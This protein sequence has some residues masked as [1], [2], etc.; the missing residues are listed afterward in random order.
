MGQNFV[1]IAP[2][3][4]KRQYQISNGDWSTHFYCFFKDK[5]KGK[6]RAFPLG[7]DLKT[8]KD[9]LK[10]LEARNIRK[11]DFD[12]DKEPQEPKEQGMTFS[13]WTKKYLEL[14]KR[15]KSLNRDEQ[16]CV[17]LNRFFGP[18]LLAQIKRTKIMEYKNL[19]LEDPIIRYGKPVEGSKVKI[20][21]VNRELS[22][23][24]HMLNL[25][26]D[27]EGLLESVPTFKLESEGY[28]A[29][30]RVLSEKEY[31]A[32]LEQ[33]PRW[34]KRV[35]IAAYETAMDRSD[36]LR[37]TWVEVDREKGVIKLAGGRTKTGVKAIIPISEELGTVLDELEEE[38][39][40]VSNLGN[41]VFTDSGKPISIHRLRNAFEK[42]VSGAG[43]KDFRFKDFR[44]TAKTRWAKMGVPVEAAMVAAGHKSVAMH[45]RYVNLKEDHVKEAFGIHTGCKH[46]KA[47]EGK[48]SVT[49]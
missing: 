33:C 3:L 11:E 15:K 25:A 26:A 35:S 32:Y 38:N 44:H 30:E 47:G 2:H 27:D 8:A 6:R 20:S 13:M 45:Y 23:L 24:R 48:K 46:E 49:A 16:H 34:L 10:V 37:L 18:L 22:C 12:K 42:V 17:H 1:R 4:Y 41:L 39:Q 29:R 31:D 28:L 21:T 40:K 36:I 14:I 19:R 5:L 7:S 9:E 43:I